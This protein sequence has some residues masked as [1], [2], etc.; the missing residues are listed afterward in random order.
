MRLQR[1]GWWSMLLALVTSVPAAGATITISA[2]AGQ[3]LEARP[4]R[5]VAR[6]VMWGEAA[7]GGEGPAVEKVAQV[8]GTV[9]WELPP[10][11]V[12]RIEVVG[13]GVWGPPSIVSAGGASARVEVWPTGRVAGMLL[14]PQDARPPREVALRF[15]SSRRL[16]TAHVPP[17]RIVCPVEH[18]RFTCQL[19]AAAD[20]DLRVKAEGFVARYF[21]HR[22]VG[23]GEDLWLGPVPLV[24]GGSVAGWLVTER[25]EPPRPEQRVELTLTPAAMT[26][27]RDGDA[28]DERGETATIHAGGFFQAVGVPPGR[29]VAKAAAVGGLRAESPPLTVVAG[30]DSELIEPLVLRPPIEAVVRIAPPTEPDGGAWRVD[31]QAA[32]RTVARPRSGQTD[33]AG[34]WRVPALVAGRY[35]VVVRDHHGRRLHVEEVEVAAGDARVEVEIERVEV[36]GRVWLGDQPLAARVVFGGRNGAVSLAT[37]SDE[38]GRFAGWVTREGPWRIDVSSAEPSVFRRFVDVPIERVRGQRV[39]RLELRLPDTLLEGEVVD[40]HGRPVDGAMLVV[41]QVPALEPLLDRRVR[42]GRFGLRGLEPGTYRLQAVSGAIDEQVR[43]DGVDVVLD[44]AAPY[45][46]ARLVLEAPL[47]VAGQV[48]SAWGAVVGAEVFARPLDQ[49][50]FTLGI[51][52]HTDFEGRVRLR[53]PRSTRRVDL[54]VMAP[55]YALATVPAAAVDAGR[56]LHLQLSDAA[57]DLVLVLDR[58]W[59]LSPHPIVERQGHAIGIGMLEEWIRRN[60]S[61]PVGDRVVVPRL[62]PGLY[63]ACRP[64]ADQPSGIPSCAEGV[65]NPGGVLELT[66][67]SN[68]SSEGNRKEVER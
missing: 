36:T 24:R 9:T 22:R 11:V 47:V 67:Q 16:G 4:V 60:G 55:G 63:R 38:D 45:A 33:A 51:S 68:S 1:M 3:T 13:D 25:G 56:P 66:L 19:P 52:A 17:T 20:L 39:A 28:T 14:P 5:L 50:A 15:A 46:H 43:S 7:G 48:T 34:E 10:D 26:E 49:P 44:E 30:R 27:A 41:L 12:W 64:R 2:A 31:L 6:P 23:P 35:M 8:P 32:G 53:L 29:Y 62:P 21:W 58:P 54:L 65:L 40:E 59:E 57:G 37:E 42:A 18:T 61:Q